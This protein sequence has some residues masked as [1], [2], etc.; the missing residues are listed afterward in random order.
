MPLFGFF[1]TGVRNILLFSPSLSCGT[2]WLSDAELNVCWCVCLPQS[3]PLI[4]LRSLWTS[5]RVTSTHWY[6]VSFL[7]SLPLRAVHS[8]LSGWMPF[9]T[10][11][12]H[13]RY[14][15]GLNLSVFS[16]EGH[17][18]LLSYT[19]SFLFLSQNSDLFS[20]TIPVAVGIDVELGGFVFV[21]VYHCKLKSICSL[22]IPS[23]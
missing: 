14:L 19:P 6:S 23:T 2:L 11:L 9:C 13:P 3:C 20:F 22:L 12:L 17:A 16:W 10:S 15:S 5:P 7:M 1:F 18:Q 4:D 8:S 21:S